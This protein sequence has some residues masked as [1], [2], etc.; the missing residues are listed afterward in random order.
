MSRPRCRSGVTGDDA[1]AAQAGVTG[2]RAWQSP[3]LE[4]VAKIWRRRGGKNHPIAGVGGQNC[5]RGRIITQVGIGQITRCR[6]R[7]GSQAGSRL[8]GHV[9]I[10]RHSKARRSAAD[11]DFQIHRKQIRR[12]GARGELLGDPLSVVNVNELTG[13]SEIGH[14]GGD[15]RRGCGGRTYQDKSAGVSGKLSFHVFCISN[16]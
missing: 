9:V 6:T 2:V 7:Q 12:A 3:D 5:V 4:G 13:G 10:Q 11:L 8:S 1:P 15:L 16:F 14:R